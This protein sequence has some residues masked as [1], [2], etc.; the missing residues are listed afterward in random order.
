MNYN[1]DNFVK[2]I[3]ESDSQVERFKDRIANSDDILA[4]LDKISDKFSFMGI[5][6]A[7]AANW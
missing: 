1:G 6:G 7:T 4:A 2:G 3:K 5:A